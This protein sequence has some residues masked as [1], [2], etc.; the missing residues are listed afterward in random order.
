MD[1][2]S[3]DF[4]EYYKLGTSLRASKIGQFTYRIKR[5]T[6]K[7][8][9][10]RIGLDYGFTEDKANLEKS[11][12]VM[13][14]SSRI[15][16]T[17]LYGIL[18]EVEEL[19]ILIKIAERNPELVDTGTLKRARE[20]FFTKGWIKWEKKTSQ[21]LDLESFYSLFEGSIMGIA[22]IDKQTKIALY[23]GRKYAVITP[24]KDAEGLSYDALI[25]ILKPRLTIIYG[26]DG[27]EKLYES[28]IDYRLLAKLAI[29]QLTSTRL[30]Q[31]LSKLYNVGKLDVRQKLELLIDSALW[32]IE[33]VMDKLPETKDLFL[34][35]GIRS[36]VRPPYKPLRKVP[37]TPRLEDENFPPGKIVMETPSKTYVNNTVLVTESINPLEPVF[38]P[39]AFIL[40]PIENRE[41]P[42]ENYAQ[43]LMYMTART[44][45]WWYDPLYL[46]E[47]LED[48]L[49]FEEAIKR[50][51]KEK[52]IYRKACKS[53]P[54]RIQ[55]APW[56]LNRLVSLCG[57]KIR[58]R[59]LVIDTIS[60]PVFA[61]IG[62]KGVIVTENRVIPDR[63]LSYK[64][65][66]CIET[67]TDNRTTYCLDEEFLERLEQI[68]PRIEIVSPVNLM[69]GKLREFFKNDKKYAG[70][71][72]V[73]V[74]GLTDY[75]TSF[76]ELATAISS[77]IEG[78]T[79][80]IA[81]NNAIR[82][83]LESVNPELT[84][85][86]WS[87]LL[88]S[89]SVLEEKQHVIIV[90]PE[91]ILARQLPLSYYS[92]YELPEAFKELIRNIALKVSRISHG[93]II[94][95][96]TRVR[97]ELLEDR[98]HVHVVESKGLPAVVSSS[99]IKEMHMN[100]LKRGVEVFQEYWSKNGGELSIRGYQ[101]RGIAYALS[102]YTTGSPSVLVTVLPT[103]A[104]KSA[105]YQVLGRVLGESMMGLPAIIVS[106]L[107]TLIHDQVRSL[108]NKGFIAEYIDAGITPKKRRIILSLYENGLLDFLYITPERF[109]D[110]IVQ[111]II[112]PPR[113]P[114]FIALDEVHTLS[115]WGRTF[116]PSYLHMARILV[117]R[118]KVNPKIPI[119]G[120]TAT[121]PPG[122]DKDVV[123]ILVGGRVDPVVI[124]I[125]LNDPHRKREEFGW[126]QSRPL[127]LKGPVIR[128][129]LRFDVEPVTST[130]QRKEKLLYTLSELSRRLN[131][132]RAPYVGIVFTGFVESEE[133][134]W[135]NVDF[136]VDLVN[137]KFGDGYSIGYHGSLSD[138]ERL[139]IERVIYNSSET[140][141]KP[142]IVVATKAFGMG[143]DIPNIR[144]VIHYMLSESIEDYY[145]EAGRAG[146][147]GKI[148]HII[149]LYSNRD[150][151]LRKRLM[152][153][154][155]IQPSSL[156]RTYNLLVE[157]HNWLKKHSMN[158]EVDPYTLI[159]PSEAF[160][161]VTPVRVRRDR[162]APLRA[163]QKILDILAEHEMLTYES[164][165]TN[166]IPIKADY[167]EVEPFAE[168]LYPV[169]P[170]L[171]LVTG[172]LPR[173]L[174]PGKITYYLGKI[175]EDTAVI[176][177]SLE[178][179]GNVIFRTASFEESYKK[180]SLDRGK[181][182]YVVIRLN[183]EY[184]YKF[185]N[186][187]P[188]TILNYLFIREE[189]DFE[190]IEYL[191]ELLAKAVDAKIQ[192]KLVDRI[193]KEG[194]KSY[195]SKAPASIGEEFN[196]RNG[197][198][199]TCNRKEE[200]ILPVANELGLL[201]YNTGFNTRRVVLVIER[202]DDAKRVL[203]ILL[204]SGLRKPPTVLK[205]SN[206]RK[207]FARRGLLYL[208]DKGYIVSL[209]K[210]N[211]YV[212]IEDMVKAYPYLYTYLYKV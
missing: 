171:Y 199:K 150:K 95:L 83:M 163:A 118:N 81:P 53:L 203:S 161:P 35:K 153:L 211:K 129:E 73:R 46:I 65:R 50:L 34:P 146:R 109:E 100:L 132:K 12:E 72:I 68:F 85:V 57:S 178:C 168:S 21:L 98:V 62:G 207:G 202:E 104:G 137:K 143:V 61:L 13:L 69:P 151:N 139:G 49:E 148:A 64:L 200:C 88:V 43:L 44:M 176:P 56:N 123:Q 210:T 41:S 79:L 17:D 75:I 5:K 89:P 190:R 32:M 26:V 74:F 131:S 15:S 158:I 1:T 99:T 177:L 192:G 144:Y 94:T 154:E 39:Y 155:T 187:L 108:N 204:K 152:E 122:I 166:L 113:R 103:G 206:L 145:Q 117:E 164:F 134:P 114:L 3:N 51:V 157:M 194:I 31:V 180:V 119:L 142:R 184:E 127:I 16:F 124:N 25:Q 195:F 198:I 106:P 185:L 133:A 167:K 193:V 6:L 159:L 197:F 92:T 78:D 80:V 42:W 59:K 212:D 19:P 169:A 107:R 141:S 101:K 2:D 87:E 183:P 20:S 58:G 71:P 40:P 209:L 52:L 191:D 179:C 18:S 125:D 147:D 181:R 140:G 91:K 111:D 116:R 160:I 24:E 136:V 120:F 112:N 7:S 201:L 172:R 11:L 110:P 55:V 93:S 208:M 33:Y 149:S 162:T 165:T 23:N 175:K 8:E 173:G 45:G 186:V 126:H 4:I 76:H 189:E 77:L 67:Y 22:V 14:K 115:K 86:T 121:L 38:S 128:K 102:M 130:N 205:Y 36:F 47:G 27:K 9:L 48:Y 196:F 70:N 37:N 54:P 182:S 170:K 60:N 188:H 135:A 96:I 97:P 10:A 30:E 63:K 174:S 84:V 29:P 66:D 156:L 90:N 28:S 138:K 105:I 82:K